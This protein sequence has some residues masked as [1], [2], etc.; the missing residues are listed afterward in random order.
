MANR[1]VRRVRGAAPKYKWCGF[2]DSK[3]IVSSPT[4]ASVGL[5]CLSLALTDTQGEVT[6][7]RILLWFSITRADFNQLSILAFVVAKQKAIAAS[8]LPVEVLDPLDVTLPNFSMSN[9]DILLY[10]HLPIP[11]ILLTSA[12]A[13]FVSREVA[14]HTAEFKGRRRLARTN[15]LLS[16]TIASDVDTEVAVHTTA[17][18]LIRFS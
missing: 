11:A 17:R 8:G 7:E 2:A 6:V 4:A 9:K 3:S 16:L 18:T 15:H 12:D 5:L 10:G 13:G 1:T 14:V